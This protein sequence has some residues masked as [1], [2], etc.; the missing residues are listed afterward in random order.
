M[1][2]IKEF[3]KKIGLFFRKYGSDAVEG[4]T[5]PSGLIAGSGG[6]SSLKKSCSTGNTIMY[7]LAGDPGAVRI[8]WGAGRAFPSTDLGP[9]E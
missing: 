4:I 7:I 1:K 3:F 5:S 8:I 2:K 9:T 6:K